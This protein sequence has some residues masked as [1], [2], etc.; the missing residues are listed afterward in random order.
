MLKEISLPMDAL[1][2]GHISFPLRKAPLDARIPGKTHQRMKMVRHDHHEAE[3]PYSA[4][5]NVK[6]G[7]T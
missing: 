5:F 7:V 2:C 3:P 6:Q 4:L 1:L